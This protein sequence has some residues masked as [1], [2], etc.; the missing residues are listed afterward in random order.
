[1][2]RVPRPGGIVGKR[3]DNRERFRLIGVPHDAD[4]AIWRRIRSERVAPAVLPRD[5]DRIAARWTVSNHSA[6]RDGLDPQSHQPTVP[7]SDRTSRI[8]RTANPPDLARERAIRAGRR[9][10]RLLDFEKLRSHLPR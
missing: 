6:T 8:A 4:P 3:R 5:Q 9:R 10:I 2:Q 7:R 1:V